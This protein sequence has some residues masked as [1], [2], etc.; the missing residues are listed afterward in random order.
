MADSESISLRSSNCIVEIPERCPWTLINIPFG[1]FTHERNMDEPHIATAIG[2][3][4]VDLN[5]FV[6]HFSSFSFDTQTL[7]QPT[8]NDFMQLDRT[9]WQEV[10][11][12]IQQ[13]LTDRSSVLAAQKSDIMFPMDECTM[14]MP[15]RIGDYTDFYSSIWHATNVGKLFR[16]EEEALK[17]NWLHMPVGYHGR[18]SSVVVS[19]T[20]INRPMGQL[21]PK[22]ATAPIWGSC[23]LLDFEVEVAAFYGGK[24]NDMG[25]RITIEEAPD[26]VFG[27]VLMNDWS[28]RDIQKWE[29]V[30]LGPFNGKNFATT[31]SPWIVTMD[32]LE[33]FKCDMIPQNQQGKVP[34]PYLQSDALTSYDVN[35]GVSLTTEKGTSE[36]LGKTNTCNLYW[37]F[38]QQ[39]THHSSSGCPM[40]PGDLLGSGTISGRNHG[41]Y[42]SMLELCSYSDSGEKKAWS[43]PYT[44]SDGDS[45]TSIQDGDTITMTGF[46]QKGD[47]FLGFGECTGLVL[48]PRLIAKQ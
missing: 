37:T 13:Q 3:F 27:V 19:G 14:L 28:A 21:M 45:R 33:L 22:G 16:S 36:Q 43:F 2:S 30:P 24:P 7:K 17:P 10:R 12:V 31:I 38:T 25:R 1:V 5:R 29:Y 44:L 18:A 47:L 48:P 15:A 32:A 39:L 11:R 35:L 42:G 23:N 46:C 9:C 20:N 26:H 8:L 40:K 4:V 41:E 6:G 34:L